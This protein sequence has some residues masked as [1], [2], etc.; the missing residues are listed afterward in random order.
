MMC[1]FCDNAKQSSSYLSM[2]KGMLEEDKQRME[3]SKKILEEMKVLSKTIFTSLN[4]PAPLTKP[5]FEARNAFTLPT[6]YFQNISVDGMRLGNHF[7]HGSTRS[8]FF[9][10]NLLILF[11]KTVSQKMGLGEYFTSFNFLHF[12]K[13]EYTA[14]IKE[15]MIKISINTK[16]KVKNLMTG[17]TEEKQIVLNLIHNQLKGKIISKQ[18][19]VQSSYIQRMYGKRGDVSKI[20]A[21]ADLEGYVISVNHFSPHPFMLQSHRDFGF[22]SNRHFQEHVIDYFKAHI[23]H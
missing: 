14:S 4:W 15:D 1:E 19:A 12:S 13:Q 17:K 5:L 7:S 22:E 20:F 23:L 16:K 8:I 18:Q 10:N 21:S 9:S 6:N 11:S 3:N 2:L